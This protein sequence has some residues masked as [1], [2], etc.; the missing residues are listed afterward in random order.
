MIALLLVL[1]VSLAAE[2]WVVRTGE[3]VETIATRLGDVRLAESIR[4]LNH[5]DPDRQPAVGTVLELPAGQGTR[6][7]QEAQVINVTGTGVVT[8]PDQKPGPLVIAAHLPVGTQVCTDAESYA[9]VRLA[10]DTVGFAHDDITLLPN[11][12]MTVVDAA[13]RPGRRSSLV[14]VTE[15][16][17]SVTGTE[18]NPGNVIIQTP[19]GLTTGDEGGFRVN[20]EQGSTR[21]EAVTRPVSVM[22]AGQE[23]ALEARQGTRVKAGEAP[24]AARGLLAGQALFLP[25]DGAPLRWPD[26]QWQA[27][28]RA[29][30]YRVQI[31][32]TPDFTEIA[33]QV[34]V[35]FPEWKPD[36]LLLPYRVAG[37]WWRVAPLDR[38][39][40]EGVP[41]AERRLRVPAGVGP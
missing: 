31:A 23:V 35:P 27:V 25:E 19:S 12:C 1:R 6:D 4:A 20:V 24:A 37:Y 5:L 40:F 21:T 33:Q 29:L 10:G 28:P 39:G 9:T 36:F 41:S 2:H 16:G 8:V 17:V 22:G 30:G 13:A 26:F 38:F 3:T 34:D 18:D 7:R 14:S 11:T 32:T 15:G